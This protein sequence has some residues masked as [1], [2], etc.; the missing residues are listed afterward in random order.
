MIKFG[1]PA[2]FAAFALVAPLRAE[3]LEVR[4]DRLFVEAQIDGVSVMA[5]LDS[6]AEVTILDRDFAARLNT[7]TG[8]DVQARGTG[9]ER[10]H[11]QLIQNLPIR[12]LGT[13]LTAPIAAIIDLSDVGSRLTGGPLPVILGRELFDAG[14]LSIDI[15][16]GRIGWFAPGAI[17]AGVR[18]PLTA[19]NGIES[20]PV[21][22]GEVPVD[23]DFDLG[24]GSGLLLSRALAERLAL[25]AAGIEPGGGIGGAK[26]RAVVYVPELTVAGQ[27]FRHVRAHIDEDAR[28]DAN[29]GVAQLRAFRIV[30]DFPGRAVWLDARND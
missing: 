26:G 7:G 18:L 6:G 27:S 17:P 10:V 4:D 1:I 24:N 14:R 25:E 21:Q 23:A 3:T 8:E 20:I 28:V 22:F 9:K 15:D 12:V 30:T 16:E 11:A 29:I 2:L 13:S 19:A 5:L